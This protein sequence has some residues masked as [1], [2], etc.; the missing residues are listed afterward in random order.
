MP[1]ETK[2]RATPVGG[3]AGWLPQLS[4]LPT[5]YVHAPWEASADVLAAME[6]T[7]IAADTDSLIEGGARLRGSHA[8]EVDA[9]GVHALR[10]HVLPRAVV[11]VEGPDRGAGEGER[12]GEHG[13]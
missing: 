6:R 3:L 13:K 11:R 1:T 2:V 12:D 4:A 7:G 9:G 8:A 5:K 10:D